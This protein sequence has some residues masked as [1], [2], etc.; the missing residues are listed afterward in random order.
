MSLK[1]A[2][3]GSGSK[4]NGTL[5]ATENHCVL[6]DCGFSATEASRRIERLGV[7]PEDI[8]A[9]LVTHEHGDHISGVGVFSRRYKTPVHITAGT[10]AA[11]RD[12]AFSNTHTLIPDQAFELGDLNIQPFPVP[13][14]ARDPCQFVFSQGQARLGLLTD[15]GSITAH[16]VDMLNGCDA[17]ML[18]CNHDPDMLQAGPYPPSLCRRVGGDYGHLANGQAEQL[19]QR[20]ETSRLTR[21]IGM[22]LS[23]KNN[24]PD[25]ALQALQQGMG[26]VDSWIS[27]ACQE[28]GF[29][30]CEVELR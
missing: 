19:L 18:E 24:R 7:N 28:Q 13:H 8:D 11:C 1:F 30:W 2:S 14:D 29:E 4:G 20:L 9:I 25:L 6:V 26:C 17:L 10:H 5:I 23:E 12:T 3:L 16:I 22:H 21:L 27:V 15:V